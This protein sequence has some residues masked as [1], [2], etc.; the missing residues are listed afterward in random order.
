MAGIAP[1]AV[2]GMRSEK[3]P[4]AEEDMQWQVEFFGG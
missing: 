3:Y 1:N 2:L 4:L